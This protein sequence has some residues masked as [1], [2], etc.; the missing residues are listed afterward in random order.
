[1]MDLCSLGFDVDYV[2]PLHPTCLRLIV[3]VGIW[4]LTSVDDQGMSMVGKLVWASIPLCFF[5][6][7]Y[8][9]YALY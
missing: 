4:D 7:A 3:I 5:G 1:M 2:S 6:F 8:I 9:P